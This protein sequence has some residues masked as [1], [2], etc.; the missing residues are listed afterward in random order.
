MLSQCQVPLAA[1]CQRSR[2]SRWRAGRQWHP[3]I[4]TVFVSGGG[5]MT[6][7][8]LLAALPAK[9]VFWLCA[10]P[11]VMFLVALIHSVKHWNRSQ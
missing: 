4:R 10:P 6:M 11:V 3:P 1:C 8:I 9:T 2:S 5:I 7:P